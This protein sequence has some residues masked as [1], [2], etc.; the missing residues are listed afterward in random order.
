MRHEVRHAVNAITDLLMQDT[1][2]EGQGFS[3]I[4]TDSTGKSTLGEEASLRD[5]EFVNLVLSVPDYVSQ[6][7]W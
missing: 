2:Y 5:D 6:Q 4:E 1:G 3:M 7:V